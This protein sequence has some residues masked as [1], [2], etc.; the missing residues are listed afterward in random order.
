MANGDKTTIDGYEVEMMD[1]D[2]SMNC[3]IMRDGF[4][5]S[6]AA[7]MDEGLLWKRSFSGDPLEVRQETIDKIETW[8]LARGY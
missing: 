5:A 2:G 4:S 8:A 1:C 6:L 7:L 3:F